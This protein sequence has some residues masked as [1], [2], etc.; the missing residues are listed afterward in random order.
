[1]VNKAPKSKKKKIR[2]KSTPAAPRFVPG[3]V[4]RGRFRLNKEIGRGGHSIVFSADDLVAR[5]AGFSDCAVALKTIV[6]DEDTDPDLVSLM[7][8]EARRL[9]GL[10]HPNI[11]RVYDMDIEGN[12]H[13]MIMERLEGKTLASALRSNNGGG[14]EFK[15]VRK[16]VNDISA[17]LIFAHRQGIVHADLKPGNVFIEKSGNTK[18]IDFNIAYPVA[19]ATRELEEDTAR[20][21]GRLGAVTPRYASPQ[22]LAEEEPSEGDDVFSLAVLTCIALTGRHPFGSGNAQEA[23][24]HNFK[25]SLPTGLS[26]A[27]RSAL[28]H[29]LAFDDC[30]RTPTMARFARD[31]LTPGW[32]KTLF[33]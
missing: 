26:L 12:A 23:A 16:L 31:F 5:N 4:V 25:P 22:R 11:V 8:R 17:A 27:Q 10:I 33:G 1:M 13:F 20:I 7:H 6:V 30:N 29:A 14:M 24:E 2:K 18:L 32:K 15:Q 21:L 19:R 9:R 3:S 28:R